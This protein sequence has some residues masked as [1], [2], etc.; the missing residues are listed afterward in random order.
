[1]GIVCILIYLIGACFIIFIA[2]TKDKEIKALKTFIC[3]S[4]SKKDT[5]DY[6]VCD[7][8]A[9]KNA[10][11]IREDCLTVEE[12][13]KQLQDEFLIQ[14]SDMPVMY[15]DNKCKRH[16]VGRVMPLYSEEIVCLEE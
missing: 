1:M 12:L 9:G 2:H 15:V 4:C 13:L 16:S 6:D 11:N 5:N 10:K 8:S 14:K 7:L 3:E